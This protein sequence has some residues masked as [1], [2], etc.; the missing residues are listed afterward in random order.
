MLNKFID[1]YVERAGEVPDCLPAKKKDFIEL[2]DAD[3]Q[4]ISAIFLDLQTYMAFV[5]TQAAQL[6][7]EQISQICDKQMFG[8]QNHY[9][10]L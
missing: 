8:G 6:T 4:V 5:Q 7:E 2:L 10:Q 3:F 9:E 1:E